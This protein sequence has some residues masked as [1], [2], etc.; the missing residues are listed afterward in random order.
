[1]A[2]RAGSLAAMRTRLLIAI[3]LVVVA[4][5]G[6][7][8][9]PATTANGST[10]TIT[11]SPTTATPSTTAG[12]T[13]SATTGAPA[14]TTTTSPTVPSTTP[15]GGEPAI[16]IEEIVFAGDPYLLIG[17]GGTGLGS[18]EGYFICQFP[19]Y[20]GLPSVELQPGERLAVP[21][22]D[23]TVPDLVGVVATVEVTRPI[24]EVSATNGELGLYST[25]TFNSPDAIVDYVEWGASG[26]ARSGVAVAAGIWVD[27]GF[28]EVPT[29]LL[30]IVAQAFPTLGP[31][32][33]FAEIGG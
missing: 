27:G 11:A 24:G 26:H 17:N 3:G 33:W 12:T 22:G 15:G 31:E 4:C 29:E 2:R 10:T 5:G 21:L 8:E 28:V 1:M 14:P 18:T 7:V 16:R 13:T 23:G 25:N 30:A 32:D 6:D 20:Y 9:T 19:S